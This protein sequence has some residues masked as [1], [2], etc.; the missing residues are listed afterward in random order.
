ME[1]VDEDD[2]HTSILKH[3]QPIQ[4][5]ENDNVPRNKGAGEGRVLKV[6]GAFESVQSLVLH[7]AQYLSETGFEE[8]V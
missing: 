4:Q 3:P 6:Q 2:G 8:S 5:V 7:E 1:G